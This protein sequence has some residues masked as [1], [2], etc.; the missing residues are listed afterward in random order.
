MDE[1]SHENNPEAAEKKSENSACFQAG[2]LMDTFSCL[3]VHREQDIF[4]QIRKPRRVHWSIAWSDLMMTMFILFAVMFI[5][6]SANRDLRYGG[7]EIK[8]PA[9][10]LTGKTESDPGKE[11][12]PVET[13]AIRIEKSKPREQPME[14]FR[15]ETLQDMNRVALKADQ[16]VRII[17]PAD[18]LFDTGRAE[19][20]TQAILSLREIGDAI[21]KTTDRVTVAGHTDNVPIHSEQFASNWELSAIRA[22]RVARFLIEEMQVPAERVIISGSSYFQPINPNDTI[23][24]RSKNRRV[25]IILSKK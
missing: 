7:I 9:K 21:G 18:L 13:T 3:A 25:E 11:G 10:M 16:A 14:A 12:A 23:E 8:A 4:F 5:Y 24:N 22:C 2:T 1:Y 19:L 17:L 6:Q 20:K 15:P